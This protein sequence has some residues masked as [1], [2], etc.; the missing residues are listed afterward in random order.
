VLF[1]WSK[2]NHSLSRKINPCIYKLTFHL[3]LGSCLESHFIIL[4]TYWVNGDNSKVLV[5]LS[6]LQTSSI[7]NKALITHAKHGSISCPTLRHFPSKK[8]KKTWLNFR[9]RIKAIVSIPIFD[10][11]P[12]PLKTPLHILYLTFF[13]HMLGTIFKRCNQ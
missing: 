5:G 13:I 3:V 4:W 7:T 10:L 6:V 12:C 11:F 1:I 2:V 8:K 9:R